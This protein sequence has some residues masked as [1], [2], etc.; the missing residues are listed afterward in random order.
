MIV[1]DFQEM[2]DLGATVVRIHLQFG[3]FMDSPDKPN[4]HSLQQLAR[5]VALAEEVGLYLD[6]TGLGC[7]HKQ[8]VP[9]WYDKLEE[10]DRWA[11]QA[12]FWEH[13]GST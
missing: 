3:K 1:E 6:L 11:A 9:P 2:K 8:D 7:Y 12:A 5:L 10:Q 13:V 4:Q